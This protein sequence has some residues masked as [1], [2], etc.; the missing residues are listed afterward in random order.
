MASPLIII[1]AG[2]FSRE[3]AEVVHAINEVSPTWDLLG[4]AD[5][6]AALEGSDLGGVR[7]LGGV[8]TVLRQHPAAR[9]VVGIGRPDNYF[10]RARIVRR[11]GLPAAR[12]ATIVHPTASVARSAA[13]GPGTVVLAGVVVTASAVIGAHVAVMPAAVITHDDVIAD[14]ATLASGV[15]LGGSVTIGEGAYIGAGALVR[16]E[17]T[18]GSWSLIGMGSVVT[19]DVPPA[20]L[21]FG[22]PAQRRSGVDVPADVWTRGG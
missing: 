18:V 21:W 5:D 1:G 7:V 13:I 17:L 20:E 16:Q 4:F 15:L 6:D 10:I 12:Y 14:Y 2:G 8:E 3:A 19:R 11:L 22:S 9:M